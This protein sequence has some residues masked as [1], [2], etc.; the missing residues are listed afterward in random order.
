MESI[1]KP[2]F[3]LQTHAKKRDLNIRNWD[4]TCKTPEESGF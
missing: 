2:E 3:G 4:S 1:W